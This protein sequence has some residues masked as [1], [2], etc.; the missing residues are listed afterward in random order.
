MVYPVNSR[1]AIEAMAIERFVD[2]PMT[3]GDFPWV[4]CMFS[5]GEWEDRG[6]S[7]GTSLKW[8]EVVVLF[9]RTV[10]LTKG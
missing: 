4:F 1:F 8:S 5:R 10:R 3:N 2:L 7:T 9:S 6:I